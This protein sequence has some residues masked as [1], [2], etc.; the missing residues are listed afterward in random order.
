MKVENIKNADKF[1]RIVDEC[2]GKVQLITKNGDNLDLKPKLCQ[3]VAL[4]KILMEGNMNH[5]EIVAENKKDEEKLKMH[6]L[7]TND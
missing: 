1:F 7:Q 6:I 5:I 4:D 3:F 2:E